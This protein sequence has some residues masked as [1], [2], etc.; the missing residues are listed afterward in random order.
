MELPFFK[1]D[2]INRSNTIVSSLT[3]M[4]KDLEQVNKDIELEEAKKVEEI[5]RLEAENKE[6]NEVKFRN[7]N[8]IQN[9]N[10]LFQ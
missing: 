5:K 6:L 4:A 3:S 1:K 8:L 10:A 2:L 7:R 9:I